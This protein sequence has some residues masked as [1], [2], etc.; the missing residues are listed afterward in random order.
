MFRPRVI[1]ILLVDNGALVKTTRFQH[2]TYVGD[3]INTVEIFSSLGADELVLLD[4]SA[5]RNQREFSVELLMKISQETAMPLSVGGGIQSLNHMEKLIHAGAEKLILS[6][7]ALKDPIW[8]QEAINNF[9]SSTI[10][11]C[12]DIREFNGTYRVFINNGQIPLDIPLKDL[13]EQLVQA[14]TGEIL[15]QLIDREGT[16]SGYDSQ[17]LASIAL[18]CPVPIIAIGGMNGTHSLK[19]LHEKCGVNGFGVGRYFTHLGSSVLIN[20]ENYPD[21]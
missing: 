2:P 15:I 11:V 19:Y 14:G 10:S 6:T 20:Y 7:S 21:T 3:P 1:P 5:R 4:I 17:L 18:S 9:G 16:L 12:V 13:L 8:L